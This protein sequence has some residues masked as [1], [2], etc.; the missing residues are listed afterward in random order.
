MF[1][2][3]GDGRS[4]AAGSREGQRPGQGLRRSARQQHA[5]AP[6]EG[7]HRG[8]GHVSCGRGGVPDS[9]KRLC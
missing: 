3:Q 5:H 8:Q 2:V 7:V 9:G 4:N 1:L 6:Q